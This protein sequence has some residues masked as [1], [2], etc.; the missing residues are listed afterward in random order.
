M[1]STCAGAPGQ[2]PA[3]LTAVSLLSQVYLLGAHQIRSLMMGL[4]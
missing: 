2:M 1:R 4:R 3:S